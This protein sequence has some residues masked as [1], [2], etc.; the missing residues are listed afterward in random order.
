M[1]ACTIALV[2]AR[3]LHHLLAFVHVGARGLFDVDILAGLA[4]FHFHVRVPVVGS[5]D[6]DRV[7]G[8]IRQNLAEILD[9]FYGVAAFQGG[10]LGTLQVRLVNVAKRHRLGFGHLHRVAQ[11]AGAHGAESDEADRNAVIGAP[12][13]PGEQGGSESRGSAAQKISAWDVH[14]A[15]VGNK[16][17]AGMQA[18]RL[19]VLRH[20]ARNGLISPWANRGRT[21]DFRQNAPEI[22]VSRIMRRSLIRGDE[23][24][25]GVAV[26]PVT[27]GAGSG[28]RK[29]GGTHASLVCHRGRLAFSRES[30][31]AVS[32]VPPKRLGTRLC[33]APY[34][35]DTRHR[36]AVGGLHLD[37]QRLHFRRFKTVAVEP[38]EIIR[39][40]GRCA[41]GCRPPGAPRPRNPSR[42]RVAPRAAG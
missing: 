18:G 34:F 4:G 28:F 41:A 6:A 20:T 11:I 12:N 27:D 7:D 1:P 15:P 3:G 36:I 8:F 13:P 9:A 31:F 35:K 21:A 42:S 24:R 2:L 30:L 38:L 39:D 22:H 5:G 37:A 26:N 29:D 14:T 10:R 33:V 16:I 40:C 23:N 25:G 32:I 17:S 19:T